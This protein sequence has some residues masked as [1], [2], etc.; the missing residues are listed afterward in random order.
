MAERLAVGY[1]KSGLIFA[2]AI[3]I[4]FVAHL[5]FGLNAVL[6]FWIA[7]VLTRP[8]GASIGDSTSRSLAPQA[9]WGSARHS[10]ASLFLSA[11]LAV[12]VLLTITKRD[13]IEEEPMA[14]DAE[15]P[16]V[17]RVLIVPN[18][19]SA[20]PALVDAVR[21]RAT[22]GPADFVLLV[23]NP[24]H[25]AFD[26]VSHESP[27]G[28]HLLAEALPVLEQA[29]GGNVMG[30]IAASPNA[31]DDIVEELSAHRYHEIIL[32]TIPAHVSHWLHV[33]LPQRLAHLGYPLTTVPA[34]H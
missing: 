24:H 25:L 21:T 5:R 20:S 29:T 19:T 32:E 2:G 28:D 3:A 16:R 30:R 26:R 4:V 14:A 31:Y 34:T 23:P 17:P 12:V 7:Y 33:D 27:E 15:A 18:R 6:A 8:L 1:W 11:I 10:R 22:E 13:R 9:A